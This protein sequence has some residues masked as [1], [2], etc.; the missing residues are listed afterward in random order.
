M[1]QVGINDAVLILSL[2]YLSVDMT[3][4]WEGYSTCYQPIH[5]WMLVSYALII[6]SRLVYIIGSVM[7]AGDAG[8]FLLNL[9]QKGTV[10]QILMSL[11]WMV[12]VPFFT[13]WSALGTYWL[14]EV[15]QHTPECLPNGVHLWFVV[16]WQVL[17]YAWIIIHCGLG[18]VAWFMERRLRSVEGDLQQLEDDDTVSRWGQVSRMTDYTSLQGV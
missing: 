14:V 2:L 18:G 15:R 4:E 7:T 9:R 11:T 16:I 3:F 12:I 13:F 17:S 10:L 5:K 1:S 8:D 6:I